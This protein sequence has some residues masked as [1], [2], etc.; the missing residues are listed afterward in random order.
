[1]ELRD[2]HRYGDK[3]FD[4]VSVSVGG[5]VLVHDDSKPRGFWKLAHTDDLI[6][7]RDGQTRGAILRV[8]STGEQGTT[9]QSPLQR[10]YPLEISS[11]TP[12]ERK[13]PDDMH[14]DNGVVDE[15]RSTGTHEQDS[16]VPVRPRRAVAIDWSKALVIYEQEDD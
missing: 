9:L 12:E 10:L 4:T 13:K 11:S 8:A 6:I 7:G 2:S 3:T 5:V 14:N 15:E 16:E 1:M